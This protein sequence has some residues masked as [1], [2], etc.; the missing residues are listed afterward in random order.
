METR[1][2]DFEDPFMCPEEEND[3]LTAFHRVSITNR[4]IDDVSLQVKTIQ[5]TYVHTFFGLFLLVAR[6]HQ[7]K[8]HEKDLPNAKY[9]IEA[10]HLRSQYCIPASHNYCLTTARFLHDFNLIDDKE[11]PV[12]NGRLFSLSQ[13][14]SVLILL[15]SSITDL[16]AGAKDVVFHIVNGVFKVYLNIY[17][18]LPCLML[19]KT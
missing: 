3:I 14:Y 8:L 13:I 18:L 11:K 16:A 2:R 7:A 12:S 9:L 4:E 5:M 10:L 19:S 15:I 6:L 1:A 17:F